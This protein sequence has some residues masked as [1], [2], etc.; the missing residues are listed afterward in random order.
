MGIVNKHTNRKQN[1]QQY[2]KDAIPKSKI[3]Q[4][5]S[6]IPRRRHLENSHAVP[7]HLPTDISQN[8]QI[9][10]FNVPKLYN[11][12]GGVQRITEGSNLVP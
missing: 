12:H 1:I 7:Y 8:F 3:A 5:L 11:R 10:R 9:Y 2:I 6:S 4:F